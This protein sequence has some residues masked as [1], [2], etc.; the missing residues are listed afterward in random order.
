MKMSSTEKVANHV[1]DIKERTVVYTKP[2]EDIDF[3]AI[4]GPPDSNLR[5]GFLKS[6][7]A[8]PMESYI[9]L[10]SKSETLQT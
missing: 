7:R 5:S 1:W 10:Y 8:H 6:R 3:C 2:I 9:W 4:V